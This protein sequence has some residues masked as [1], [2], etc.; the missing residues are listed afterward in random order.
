MARWAEGGN[1]VT[2]TQGGAAVRLTSNLRFALGWE[3]IARW[4]NAR[5]WD[6][7]CAYL[8]RRL[9]VFGMMNARCGRSRFFLLKG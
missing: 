4:A 3:R 2:V 7:E 5:F 6:D 1:G 8:E 9:R